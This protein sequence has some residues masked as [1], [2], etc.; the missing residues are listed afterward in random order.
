MSAFAFTRVR[1][2]PR[3]LEAGNND[4]VVAWRKLPVP[5]NLQ[6]HF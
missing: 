3:A 5:S 2:S 4:F 6:P 1:T